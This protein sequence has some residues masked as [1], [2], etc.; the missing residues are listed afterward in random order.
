[1]MSS[2]DLY[3]RRA[4]HAGTWY[5]KNGSELDNQLQT[6]LETASSSSSSSANIRALIVP[7]A[8]YSYS[9]ST[10]AYGYSNITPLPPNTKTIFIL[11]PSHHIYL[12][13]CALSGASVVQTPLG[14]LTI[15]DVIRENLLKT[16]NFDITPQ[17]VD[18]DEHSIEMHLPYIAKAIKSSPN[19][20]VKVVP[21]MVGHVEG[22]ILQQA[23]SSLSPYLTNKENIF[24]IS[25][26]FCHWGSR[27]R[28]SPFDQSVCSE[29]HEYIRILDHDGIKLIV[30]QNTEGFLQY[31]KKT[32][33][34]ICGRNP[35]MLLMTMIDVCSSS[36][37]SAV[38]TPNLMKYA[39]SSAV[40][41]KSDSSVSYVSIVYEG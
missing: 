29:I 18:E 16:G 34:T 37:S 32:Q 10:A 27:F 14:D 33:N 23:A 35:I 15:D 26:D 4:S 8:G 17:D 39:Q 28:Y 21:I 41:K 25:S 1:M 9:G 24:I 2:F 22:H 31:L 7:H 13:R 6:W 30:A 20:D 40:V 19:T 12:E 3:K 38:L 5:T 36:S 11:G